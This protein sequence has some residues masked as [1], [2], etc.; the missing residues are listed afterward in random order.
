[1]LF[2]VRLILSIGLVCGWYAESI[3]SMY[4]RSVWRM[5]R[6]TGI[7]GL[8]GCNLG[9]STW[10]RFPGWVLW[11]SWKGIAR[12]N[13]CNSP[14]IWQGTHYLWNWERSHEI[15]SNHLPGSFLQLSA[16]VSLS[17]YSFPFFISD[18][19]DSF[20]RSFLH[21]SSIAANIP[22]LVSFYRSCIYQDGL[23]WSLHRSSVEGTPGD[24]LVCKP[25]RWFNV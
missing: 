7:P 22:K 9:C 23:I 12:P 15:H 14:E 1:M 24:V 4:H 25:D 2:T 21:L 6:Q 10:W 18:R 19:C 5:Q 16:A 17:P 13:E 3:F 20:A 11:I 8:R